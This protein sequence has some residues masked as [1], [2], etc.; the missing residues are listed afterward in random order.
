MPMRLII[1]RFESTL[2]DFILWAMCFGCRFYINE[3]NGCTNAITH[4]TT[5]N[6]TIRAI[7]RCRRRRR[8]CAIAVVV[9]F[10]R[11]QGIWFGKDSHTLYFSVSEQIKIE[12]KIIL[13]ELIHEQTSNL[14][15]LNQYLL[16]NPTHTKIRTLYGFSIVIMI[17]SIQLM[18]NEKPFRILI[19]VYQ[20]KKTKN[21]WCIFRFFADFNRKKILRLLLSVFSIFKS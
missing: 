18:I 12:R 16:I 5:I 15:E 21:V 17:N 10:R 3:C 14:T 8:R 19:N 13:L 20:W 9:V 6:S 1:I 7:R 11:W 4:H 2:F